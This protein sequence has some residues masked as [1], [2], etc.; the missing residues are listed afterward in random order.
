M[1]RVLDDA[2]LTQATYYFKFYLFRA[3][4]KAGMGDRYL[5][6]LGAVAGDARSRPDDVGGDARS[7]TLRFTRLERAP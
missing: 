3:L 4:Q 7:H 2:S 6:L 1:T 5:D